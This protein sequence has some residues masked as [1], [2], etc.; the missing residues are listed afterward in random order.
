MTRTTIDN[1]QM[2]VSLCIIAYNEEKNM[3]ALLD[4][5][6]SQTYPHEKIEVLLV[7]GLST[8]KT[9]DEMLR[10]KNEKSIEFYD[11]KVLDNPKRVQP[12]GWNVGIKNSVGDVFI[13]VDA[14]A[15]LDN[16]FI[17]NNVKCI[18]SGEDV[19]GGKITFKS[20]NPV[21]LIAENSMF[22][23]GVAKWRKGTQDKYISTVARTC[24]RREVFEK[25]GLFNEKLLRSE[26]NEMHYRIRKAGY[27]ICYDESIKSEHF[28]RSTVRG[29]IKQKYGNGKYV[30]L[31]TKIS[32]EIFSVY[33]YVPF[34]FVACALIAL[35]LSIVAI[36]LKNVAF[37]VPLF[38]G[39]GLYAIIDLVL[40]VSGCAENKM[41]AAFFKLFVL[42][43]LMHFAYGFGTAIGFLEIPFVK[44]NG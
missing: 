1:S 43:P 20:D 41:P 30:G 8:D 34:A 37:A 12:S 13:R 31:T 33:H 23:S 9:K 21:L 14:H 3:Q 18:E 11:I 4:S 42:F 24:Y 17:L 40:S 10:F 44:L 15:V 22:G 36:A 38:V 6:I 16:D 28:A 7:D 19:C 5:V 2:I 27:K 39:L 25:V 32:P 26:D 35:I 29:M